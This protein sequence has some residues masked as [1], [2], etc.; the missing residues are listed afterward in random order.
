MVTIDKNDN[1]LVINIKLDPH[2]A[3]IVR[4]ALLM[5]VRII[6]QRYEINKKIFLPDEKRIN[7]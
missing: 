3:D 4:R 7:G 1:G 6:E 5:I 2:V